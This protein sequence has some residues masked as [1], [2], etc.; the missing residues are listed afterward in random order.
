MRFEFAFL[1]IALLVYY[2][3]LWRLVARPPTGG[4]IVPQ[5]SPPGD[6]TPAEMR[7]LRVGVSDNKSVAAVIAHMA[8]RRLISV[9]PSGSEYVIT[10]LV[11][12]LPGELPEEESDAFRA[13]FA[14]S[15]ATD[16]SVRSAVR[17]P[18]G[19]I[20]MQNAFRLRPDQGEKLLT[21]QAAISAALG[22]RLGDAY[23]KRNLEYSV[24][25][26]ALSSA[27]AVGSA[28]SFHHA[29]N[30][31]LMTLLFVVWA[32]GIGVLNIAPVIRGAFE[33]RM[34]AANLIAMAVSLLFFLCILG[35]LAAHIAHISEP[36]FALSLLVTSLLNCTFPFLLQAPTK[37]GRERMDQVEGFREF[38]SSVELDSIDRMNNPH[39]TPTLKIDHLAYAIALDLKQAWGDYLVNAMFNTVATG[40]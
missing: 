24:P 19:N 7:Y 21:I 2:V 9:T 5:Y 6:M 39:W 25:A 11:D 1:P 29:D 28:V 20:A 14:M 32:T 30:I 33:G 40:K 16:Q 4:A 10:R 3:I 26:V 18:Y 36:V 35:F 37:L 17:W 27:L 23:F 12:E 22:R 8:A 15:D 34:S 13:M 31:V 38:L